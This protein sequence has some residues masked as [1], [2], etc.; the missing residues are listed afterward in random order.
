MK[1]QEVRGLRE[2]EGESGNDNTLHLKSTSFSGKANEGS[3]VPEDEPAQH[4]VFSDG[5]SGSRIDAIP[6]PQWIETP[7]FGHNSVESLIEH[8]RFLSKATTVDMLETIPSTVSGIQAVVSGVSDIENGILCNFGK[9][10]ASEPVGSYLGMD[11]SK[12]VPHLV[13]VAGVFS[14]PAVRI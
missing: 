6:L 8:S 11:A 5:R 4:F 9:A 1:V 7:K 3:H 12:V 2:M 13:Y 10:P 14:V